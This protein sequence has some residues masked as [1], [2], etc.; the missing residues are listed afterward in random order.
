MYMKKKCRDIAMND[1][2]LCE[3]IKNSMREYSLRV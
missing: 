3:D 2:F 1:G